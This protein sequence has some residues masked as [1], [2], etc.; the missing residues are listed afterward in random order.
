MSAPLP[1][2]PVPPPP[3]RPSVPPK[4]GVRATRTKVTRLCEQCCRDIHVLGVARAPYPRPSR[5]RVIDG[6]VVERLCEAHKVARCSG[7]RAE[8]EGGTSTG[9]SGELM[10]E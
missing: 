6:E 9:G 4:P 7:W 5:W 2:M 1:G 3:L 10:R 8:S